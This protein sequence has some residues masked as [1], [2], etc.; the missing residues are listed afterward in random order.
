MAASLWEAA[1]I[2]FCTHRESKLYPGGVNPSWRKTPQVSFSGVRKKGPLLFR[3]R[4]SKGENDVFFG[5]LP[6]VIPLPP[7]RPF[8]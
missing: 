5:S 6:F 2:A 8:I 3:S 1:I 7:L 4:S